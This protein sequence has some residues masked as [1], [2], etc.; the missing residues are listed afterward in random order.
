MLVTGI[1]HDLS[2]LTFE[3]HPGEGSEEEVVQ[4]T[5][6]HAAEDAVLRLTDTGQEHD[7]ADQQ[8][9]AKVLVDRVPIRLQSRN[10][11]LGH[12]R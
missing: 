12:H 5:G 1:C 4:E 3:E 10:L 7:L 8:A 9:D 11:E 2:P 6:N